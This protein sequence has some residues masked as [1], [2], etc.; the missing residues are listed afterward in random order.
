MFSAGTAPKLINNARYNRRM[1]KAEVTFSF[2]DSP[3]GGY[4]AQAIGHSIFT[5]ANTMEEL[6][7]NMKDAVACH[8]GG[9]KTLPAIRLVKAL[10]AFKFGCAKGDFTVPDDFN[11]SDREIE[12]LSNNGHLFPE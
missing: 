5:Q 8:F 3:D 6:E 2:Q 11:E 10:P 4:E 1:P 12:H 9:K 7:A